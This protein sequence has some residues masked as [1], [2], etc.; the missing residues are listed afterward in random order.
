[1]AS[2]S[3]N[4]SQGT[5]ETAPY[6]V[7]SV[8]DVVMGHQPYLNV[9]NRASQQTSPVLGMSVTLTHSYT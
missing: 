1:M 3:K 8:V 9:Y 4:A 6:T 7:S 2:H 5:T